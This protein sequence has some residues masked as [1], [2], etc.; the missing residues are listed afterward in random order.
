MAIEKMRVLHTA[1]W[2]LGRNRKFDDYL[3]QQQYMMEGILDQLEK[4]LLDLQPNEKVWFILAGDVFDRNEDTLL[5]EFSLFIRIFFTKLL[6]LKNAYGEHFDFDI[7]DGN[8]DRKPKTDEPSILSCLTSI[9]ENVQVVNEKYF[10]DRRVLLLPFRNL[11]EQQIREALEKYPAQFV[12]AHEC[13]ARMRTDTGWSPPRDQDH[14]VDINNVMN[15]NVVGVFMGDIHKCQALDEQRRCWYSGSPITLDHGHRLPKGVL[16]HFYR[17]STDGN[18]EIDKEPELMAID[19]PRIRTHYQLGVLSDPNDLPRKFFDLH[20]EGRA[21]LQM[22]ITPEV[23]IK[24]GYEYPDLLTSTFVAYTTV[25]DPNSITAVEAELAQEDEDVD[26]K[27]KAELLLIDKW[28]EEYSKALS[29]D[30]RQ[31]CKESIYRDFGQRS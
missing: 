11:S 2:H 17:L 27:L 10:P 9:S 13:L 1:D 3:Q 5:N 31:K 4:A 15:P 28:F 21:Y 20:G 7:I 24:L 14:Y 19:D 23:E 29:K 26:A 16:H 8:H 18:W 22:A 6:Q 12:V 30:A 25:S